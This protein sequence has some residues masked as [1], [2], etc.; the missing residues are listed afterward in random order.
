MSVCLDVYLGWVPVDRLL[1]GRLRV[2]ILI[3][4]NINALTISLSMTN[5]MH[6]SLR[7]LR[8]EAVVTT[9]LPTLKLNHIVLYLVSINFRHITPSARFLKPELVED[10]AEN[11]RAWRCESCTIRG[12]S[13]LFK[14]SRICVFYLWISHIFGLYPAGQSTIQL[15]LLPDYSCRY[16]CM[17]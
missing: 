13:S 1:D 16:Q 7:I 2:G 12:V 15:F 5:H 3:T 8:L 17:Y 9:S 6:R 14:A 4:V 10:S 11:L